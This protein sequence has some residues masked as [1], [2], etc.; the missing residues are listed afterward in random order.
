MML[1]REDIRA[2]K[3]VFRELLI[4]EGYQIRKKK[5][6]RDSDLISKSKAREIVGRARLQ[7]LIDNDIIT[8]RG[9]GKAKNSAQY[10]SKKKLLDLHNRVVL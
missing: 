9:S 6:K 7:E 3:S 1:T 8:F 5:S 4:E 10:T 2:L